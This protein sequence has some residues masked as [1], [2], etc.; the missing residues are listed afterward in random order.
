MTECPYC[1]WRP[2][3]VPCCADVID[4][5]EDDEPEVEVGQPEELK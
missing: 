5:P 4:E 2:V 3:G 1:V